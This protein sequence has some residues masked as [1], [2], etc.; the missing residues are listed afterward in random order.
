MRGREEG[1]TQYWQAPGT[2]FGMSHLCE[3][4]PRVDV[5]RRL[6]V[7]QLPG[8][9]PAADL[10]DGVLGVLL[11]VAAKKISSEEETFSDL[12]LMIF[13]NNWMGGFAAVLPF[14]EEVRHSRLRR[15]LRCGCLRGAKRGGLRTVTAPKA[16]LPTSAAS[17][18]IKPPTSLPPLWCLVQA[19]WR[20]GDGT[21]LC[22][23]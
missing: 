8:S 2:W 6:V 23:Q 9:L 21:H 22:R 11:E 3:V 18:G 16:N 12:S 17:A 5:V 10:F 1:L 13:H 19:P 4:A 20:G 15:C 14:A 7:M